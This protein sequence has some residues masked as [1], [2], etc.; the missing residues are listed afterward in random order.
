M[1]VAFADFFAHFVYNFV[2]AFCIFGGE[3]NLGGN[4]GDGGG[5]SVDFAR[6]NFAVIRKVMSALGKSF[7]ADAYLRRCSIDIA[8]NIFKCRAYSLDGSADIGKIADIVKGDF[9][10][11]VAVCH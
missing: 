5:E 10:C 1:S 4:G 3:G 6:L 7:R 8:E 11:E 2:S 9:F